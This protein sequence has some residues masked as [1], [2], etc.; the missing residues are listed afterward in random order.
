MAQDRH[1]RT[2]GLSGGFAARIATFDY[3]IIPFSNS[4]AIFAFSLIN[5]TCDY[6]MY[7][8]PY[9]PHRCTYGE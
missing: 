8:S 5:W 1:A 3:N 6:D 9:F 4:D 2:D 7:F